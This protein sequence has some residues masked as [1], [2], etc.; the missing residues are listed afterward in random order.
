MR[1]SH[2]SAPCRGEGTPQGVCGYTWEH[3][4]RCLRWGCVPLESRHTVSCAPCWGPSLRPSACPASLSVSPLCSLTRS[5]P[6]GPDV[7]PGKG[8]REAGRRKAGGWP[9][10]PS[11]TV[12]SRRLNVLA[13]TDT[14]RE[15]LRPGWVSSN[16]HASGSGALNGNKSWFLRDSPCAGVT[17]PQKVNELRSATSCRAFP[18]NVQGPGG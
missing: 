17:S 6:R 1:P 12:S 18:P 15:A 8:Q 14:R 3:R 2:G 11:G 7:L 10:L 5:L 16:L 13:G 4:G 9:P